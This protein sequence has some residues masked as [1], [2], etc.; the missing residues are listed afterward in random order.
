[1]ELVNV[2]SFG[3]NLCEVQ[4]YSALPCGILIPMTPEDSG[5]PRIITLTS[6][7]GQD[8]LYTAA[9]KAA[10]I[11]RDP[12]VRIVDITHGIRPF[13]TNQAAF[14]L[15]ASIP[16]FPQ[17]TVHLIAIN[18]NP[19]D[20]YVHRVMELG[21][22]Y[23]IGLDDGI[24]SLI[25]D[26]EPD[27]IHN[28]NVSSESHIETFPERHV[29][30]QVACHLAQGGV[31]AVI[32]PPAEGWVESQW[33]RPLIGQDYVQGTILHVDRFGNLITNIDQRTFKDVGRD[34]PFKIPL[35]SARMD[36]T[37]IHSHYA[38]VPSGER[39]ALFNHMGLLEIAIRHGA[40]GHGGG[41]SQLFGFGVGDTLRIE[42][43]PAPPAGSL[44]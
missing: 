1:M 21:G 19:S 4:S 31:P 35:R 10:I 7:Y 34:R 30:V 2:G 17:G 26:R 27:A 33:Q 41:A 20:D 37:R 25:A 12:S 36:L 23:F 15:R 3:E 28:I 40:D 5:T 16:H 39:L 13:D 11:Q 43:E 6:D 32:G 9:L 29:F 18:T 44:I 14:A 24:F 8:S 38:G 42:F 22:Q